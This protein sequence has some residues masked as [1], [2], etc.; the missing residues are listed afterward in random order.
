MDTTLTSDT[1]ECFSRYA[2]NV[3][4]N[5]GDGNGAKHV[6]V[7]VKEGETGWVKWFC[8]WNVTLRRNRRKC[9][10][11]QLNFERYTVGEKILD[12]DCCGTVT[13]RELGRTLE[14]SLAWVWVD[15]DL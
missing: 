10:E 6:D 12:F 15:L 8:F 14:V 13:V 5:S 7:G 2:I 3:E 11:A 9:M 4:L 1:C